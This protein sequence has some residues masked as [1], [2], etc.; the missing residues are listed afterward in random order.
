M[1]V[2]GVKY[3]LLS[4]IFIV[5]SAIIFISPYRMEFFTLALLFFSA[6]VAIK[7]KGDKELEEST[8]P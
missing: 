7:V 4:K 8:R 1:K 6:A 2:L 3:T 5:I